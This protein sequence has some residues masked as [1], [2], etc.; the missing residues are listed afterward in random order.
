METDIF[1][2]IAKEKNISVPEGW[3]LEGAAPCAWLTHDLSESG[4]IGD[5]KNSDSILGNELRKVLVDHWTALFI[6][7]MASQWPDV[8]QKKNNKQ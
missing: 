5:S 6:N 3:S 1:N 2:I 8:R 7:L 4:V